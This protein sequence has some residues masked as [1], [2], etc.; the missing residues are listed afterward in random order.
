MSALRQ[1]KGL[2]L[3]IPIVKE[4]RTQKAFLAKNG[5]TAERDSKG[6]VHLRMAVQDTKNL[7]ISQAGK[8]A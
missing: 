7:L 8:F 2:N 3:R 5:V 1:R 6:K 4:L